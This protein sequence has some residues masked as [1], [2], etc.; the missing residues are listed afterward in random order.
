MYIHTSQQ[1]LLHWGLPAPFQVGT[2]PLSD[3]TARRNH[4]PTAFSRERTGREE[5]LEDYPK[6]S[7]CPSAL[8]E[9]EW[10]H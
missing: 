2:T 1:S 9:E 6:Y 8:V 4:P 10:S 3:G 7:L 5:V